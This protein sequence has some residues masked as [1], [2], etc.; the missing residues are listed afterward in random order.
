M[1]ST[2]GTTLPWSSASAVGVQRFERRRRGL[3]QRRIE[4]LNRRERLAERLR[5]S[6]AA[7]VPSAVS[8]CS[9]AG[10][11]DLLARHHLAGLGVDRLEREHVVAAERPMDPA[12]SAF[13]CSRCAMSRAIR[14]A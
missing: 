3:R 7:A 8:T 10:D 11:L 9:L 13:N 4:P 2:R 5:A 14:S 1:A 6:R 12:T